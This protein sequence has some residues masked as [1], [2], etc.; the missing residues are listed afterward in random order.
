MYDCTK[1][2]VRVSSSSQHPVSLGFLFSSIGTQVAQSSDILGLK[3]ITTSSGRFAVLARDHSVPR[4][5][6]LSFML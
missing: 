6:A 4:A 1:L 5:P 3:F 2:I